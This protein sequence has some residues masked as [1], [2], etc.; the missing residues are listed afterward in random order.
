[1]KSKKRSKETNAAMFNPL[2]GSF[3]SAIGQLAALLIN[4]LTLAF[5]S[6]SS[7]HLSGSSLPYFPQAQTIFRTFSKSL[8]S[9]SLS[10]YNKK[11]DNLIL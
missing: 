6:L 1:M 7:C 2:T 11:S 5:L 10:Q 4:T 9:P 8:L 3:M